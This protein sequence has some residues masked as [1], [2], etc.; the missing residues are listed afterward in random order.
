MKKTVKKSLAALTA[1]AAAL[2]MNITAFAG[3]WIQDGTG[4]WYDYGNGT[5]P[6]S[7]WQWIDGNHDGIAECYYFDQ[8]GYCLMNTITPDAY[9]VDGNGAWIVNGV[10]QTKNVSSASAV[11]DTLEEIEGTY[12]G[13]YVANQGKT[14]VDLKVFND[15]GIL[16]A[17]VDFYNLP[18]QNNAK[19]G[20]FLS[21][22][23][24]IGD[25]QYE[26]RPD[27][28]IERPSGYDTINWKVEMSN[29]RLEGIGDDESDFIIVC[30]KL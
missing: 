20:K 8:Y 22:I 24:E 3:Q 13:Y 30:E 19:E 16:W 15:M 21:R 10:V 5:W 18:G 27:S 14:G 2:S 6:A 12:R 4:W 7:S 29:G 1:L 17:E 23:V 26:I 11:V 28:W 9:T 25:G